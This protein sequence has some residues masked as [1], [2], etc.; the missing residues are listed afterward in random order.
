MKKDITPFRILMIEDNPGD[1][2]II[3]DFLTEQ[4]H[5]PLIKNAATAKEAIEFLSVPGQLFDV[6]LMDLNLPDSG[7]QELVTK[8]LEMACDCPI[9]ILT[10]YTD[11]GFS[12]QSIGLGIH[13]YLLKDDLNATTLYKS[14]IYAIERKKSDSALRN[15]EKRYSDLFNL[16][17]QSMMVFDKKTF[18]FLQVN[19]AMINLYGYSKEEFLNMTVMD[20]K[21]K[22]DVKE[23]ALLIRNT[24][25]EDPL[26]KRT[27]KHLT[28]SGKILQIDVFS[29]PLLLN[30]RQCISA[31]AI[32]VTEKNQQEHNLIKAII[33]TQEDERYEIG[34]ELHDNVCQILAVSQ[35]ALSILQTSV[36]SEGIPVFN[37]CKENI[38]LALSEIRDLSHRL[39]PVFFN[40]STLE[41]AFRRLI[42]T[43]NTGQKFK[44]ALHVD[45]KLGSYPLSLQLQ[46]NL[47]RVLQEQLRNILKY[48]EATLIEVDVLIFN[49][50]IKMKISDNGTGFDPTTVKRGIGLANI[51][52]RV[53]LF[54]GN[55]QLITA[56]GA[57]C[58]LLL[59]IP[60]QQDE[61]MPLKIIRESVSKKVIES[62]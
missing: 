44:I 5:A 62:F 19:K 14:I 35:M 20:I 2:Y 59:D 57:G 28:K 16:S 25:P 10:G 32:D 40:D 29:S 7:G 1:V 18:R 46:L 49:N 41:E 22:E 27:V 37:Q 50:K 42:N 45:E 36:P 58:T 54:A 52:R 43:F 55:F 34:G 39:A 33:K 48:A 60:L 30:E 11:I 21:L 53:E 12:I 15:S 38:A 4:I 24:K 31:I 17:P 26:F 3:E 8:M 9:I 51:Q 56:P 6:I 23:T 13:D 47:Y 61:D